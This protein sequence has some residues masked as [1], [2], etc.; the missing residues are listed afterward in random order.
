MPEQSRELRRGG[1]PQPEQSRPLP[2]PPLS[3]KPSRTGHGT[4]DAAEQAEGGGQ[5]AHHRALVKAGRDGESIG[6]RPF[7]QR[8]FM[9]LR[10]KG[11]V[12][13]LLT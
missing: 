6:N 11:V 12:S 3:T 9:I 10:L 2:L 7:T 1:S 4:V 5:R 8:L 13:Q